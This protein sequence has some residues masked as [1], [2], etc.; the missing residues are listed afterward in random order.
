MGCRLTPDVCVCV[1]VLCSVCESYARS[2]EGEGPAA[3]AGRL[4]GSAGDP[5]GH[6]CGE[7]QQKVRVPRS[8]RFSACG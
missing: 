8:L 3:A 1:C 6:R 2:G 7:A 4:S 5:E